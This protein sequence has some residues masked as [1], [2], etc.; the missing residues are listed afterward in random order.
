MTR[1]SPT[2]EVAYRQALVSYT[3]LYVLFF[4]GVMHFQ[5]AANGGMMSEGKKRAGFRSFDRPKLDS[6]KLPALASICAALGKPSFRVRNL[7]IPAWLIL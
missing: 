6:P 2:V 3:P 1:L 5:N 7:D 4:C